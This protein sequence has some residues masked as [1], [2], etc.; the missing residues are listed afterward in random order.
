MGGLFSGCGNKDC[1]PTQIGKALKIILE[2]DMPFIYNINTIT[3]SFPSENILRLET[4]EE[5]DQYIETFKKLFNDIEP[6][7]KQSQ[8]IKTTYQTFINCFNNIKKTNKR[9]Y[10][11]ELKPETANSK[12][13]LQALQKKKEQIFEDFNK[14]FSDKLYKAKGEYYRDLQI[15]IRHKLAEYCHISLIDLT[16]KQIKEAAKTTYPIW[17]EQK[18]NK[19]MESTANQACLDKAETFYA[20]F[21]K[22]LLTN[23]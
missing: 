8:N 22:E 23:F 20:T 9:I 4:A 3:C 12:K 2:D 5:I 21:I 7:N 6:V 16:N 10:N 1:T 14:S 11:A 13:R 15:R 17:E 18:K 19:E